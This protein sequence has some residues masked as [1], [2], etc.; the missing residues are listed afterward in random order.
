MIRVVLGSLRLLLIESSYLIKLFV[1]LLIIR[2]SKFLIDLKEFNHKFFICSDKARKFLVIL[3]LWISLLMVLA[4]RKSASQSRLGFWIVI[5]NLFCISRFL[6]NAFLSFFIFFEL[7]LI[8]TL[9]IILGWG[10]QPERIRAGSYMLVYTI[11]GSLP[12]LGSIFFLD[13]L[14]F[15]TSLFLDLRVKFTRNMEYSLFRI[16]WIIAFLIKLP[17]FGVHLWLPKA[18]VEA[19]VGGSMILAGVLL[20]LGAYGIF[21]SIKFIHLDICSWGRTLF[22]WCMSGM[23]IIGLIC[24]RQ[25]DLKSLVAYS[26]VAHMSIIL[27]ACFRL[28]KLGFLGLVSMLVSHGLCSSG[29]FFGVQCLYN[30]RGSRRIF[31]NRRIINISPIFIMFWFLLCVGNASAPPSLNILREY[32]L[33]FELV[34]FGTIAGGLFSGTGVFLG[35]LFSIYLYVLVSSGKWSLKKFFWFKKR[36]KT[37]ILF[38]HRFPLFFLVFLRNSLFY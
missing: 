29:L 1:I 20:K 5:L 26:S 30:N 24:F 21:R 18:H 12:L 22:I 31:L 25:C 32:L 2:C 28:H 3:R 13:Q 6:R 19:P 23:V 27:G 11:L 33:I 38:L 14:N 10:A 9:I 17:I 34:N 15:S 4:M 7:C 8:P 35:G 36:L 16:F 37:L